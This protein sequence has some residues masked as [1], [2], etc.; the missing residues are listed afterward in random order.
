MPQE[1]LPNFS[2]N[3]EGYITDLLSYQKRD[4]SL[5]YF[6]GAFPLFTHAADDRKCFRM[7]TSQFVVC[8]RCKQVD[9][10][11]AFGVSTISVKRSVK[12]YR[13]G[14]VG[15]FFQTP[16]KRGA[17]V[18]TKDVLA[19]AQALLNEGFSRTDISERLNIKRDTFN[20][21]ILSGR[22]VEPQKKNGV[23]G[24]T[25]SERSSEDSQSAMGMGC[26][27]VVERVCAATG[28]LQEAPTR[29]ETEL[30]VTQGGVLWAMPAL[31][32]N[33]LLSNVTKFFSLPK[34]F[35]SCVHIFILLAYMALTRIKTPE[36]LRYQPAG[37]GGKLLG[38]DRI[39]EVRT[40]REKIKIL[41]QPDQIKEW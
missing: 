30:D 12:K 7:I 21:A 5:F 27:R 11:R 13:Q 22:L 14:D 8:G 15:A 24:R 31:L 6:H 41:A 2:S 28:Q 37:E 25:K 39:P 33:G 9:I 36:Q 10:V 23:D 26:T 20:K 17:S 35:Y 29:F 32:S 1:F 38:L 3:G 4:G 40:L 16:N 34:G 18:L 19:Q